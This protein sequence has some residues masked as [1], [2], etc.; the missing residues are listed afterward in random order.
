MVLEIESQSIFELISGFYIK[1]YYNVTQKF[2]IKR[3]RRILLFYLIQKF[4][5]YKKHGRIWAR[6]YLERDHSRSTSFSNSWTVTCPTSRPDV[7]FLILSTNQRLRSAPS[8]AAASGDRM[9]SRAVGH[10]SQSLKTLNN[11]TTTT[12]F[13]PE[14]PY[15][16][17][18]AGPQGWWT[19]EHLQQPPTMDGIE[20]CKSRPVP[21]CDPVIR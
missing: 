8:A 4:C 11:T 10:S 17:D 19:T 13:Q 21:S 3:K 12:T 20:K 9:C 1:S 5:G 2:L 16:L 6:R 14:L 7:A 18:G 15:S